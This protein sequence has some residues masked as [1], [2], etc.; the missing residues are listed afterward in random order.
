MHIAICDDNVADRKQTER[1]LEREADK[2]IAEGNPIY[3]FTFGSAGSLLASA[4]EYDV[5]FLDIK[6]TEGEDNL[7]VIGK[8]REKGNNSPI[9]LTVKRDE[10]ES[11]DYPED[12]LFLEKEIKVS[13]LHEMIVKIEGYMDRKVARIE[14]RG[15][16]ETLYVR[17]Q[18]I[19]YAEQSGANTIITFADGRKFRTHGSAYNLFQNIA[20]KHET[21][22]MPST[23]AVL[24][25]RYVESMTGLGAVRMW[26]GKKFRVGGEIKKY[27]RQTM[28][29]LSKE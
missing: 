15:E 22:V 14:L 5:I 27:V 25:I 9:V 23:G 26:D 10:W 24:N 19:G 6:E 17:E 8:L 28:E 29:K 21:F 3:K 4:I 7:G 2:W 13:E 12:I 16:E 18:D 20:D 11:I 1:L